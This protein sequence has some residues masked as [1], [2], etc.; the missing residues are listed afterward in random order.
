[1]SN[2]RESA[3]YV[4]RQRVNDTSNKTAVYYDEPE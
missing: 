3:E 1:M 4:M 2:N